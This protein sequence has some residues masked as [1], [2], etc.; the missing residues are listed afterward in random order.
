VTAAVGRITRLTLASYRNYDALDLTVAS[1]MIALAG[2]NGAGKTNI[3][4]AISLFMPGRGLR[5]ADF[6]DIVKHG[7]T[8]GFAASL[9]LQGPHGETQLGAGHHPEN[10][11]RI[12]R[13][14]R[15]PVSS[16][17]A[18]AEHCRVLWL[19]PDNDGLFRGPAGE[20][21]RFLDRLVLAIDSSHGARVNALE[22]SLR[23]R[24]RLLEESQPNAAWLDAIER[25]AAET[26][27]AV[28]AAR[29]ETIT[30]LAGIALEDADGGSPFPHALL[31]IEGDL[32]SALAEMSALDVEERHRIALREGR[33][34]DKAAGRTLSGP[35]AS[36]LAVRHGPKD[37]PAALCSTGE[38][39]ALLLGLI[40]AHARLVQQ[41]SG[42]A[43]I[44]LLDEV[45][46]HLDAGR[47]QALYG[48]LAA[49]GGQVWMT[50]TDAELFEGMP[51]SSELF[52]I[53]GGGAKA[54][55]IRASADRSH[56][57]SSIAGS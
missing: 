33:W 42:I 8:G 24:N 54:L 21:R 36:D 3:L 22:K 2:D 34:R 16:A 39:K 53:A 43:P 55:E 18:F 7:A 4:E 17:T 12:C 30:R 45:A 5:R 13:I 31:A 47:R 35:N 40:L 57:T 32:E 26:A 6:G 29:R 38:Q 19:T 44:L 41:M 52:S 23:A 1:D 48:R 25:E 20:R 15:E 51:D 56:V 28:A 9:R 49:I 27:V 37:M 50:G 14:N 10:G 46:A 11:G